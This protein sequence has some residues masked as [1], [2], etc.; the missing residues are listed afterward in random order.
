MCL[1]RFIGP[2]TTAITMDNLGSNLPF[3][4]GPW[5]GVGAAR[6]LEER[7]PDVVRDV[8]V[9]GYSLR[10]RTASDSTELWLA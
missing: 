5:K 4:L 9:R 2:K 8:E 6:I 1:H 3:E 7:D 10:P